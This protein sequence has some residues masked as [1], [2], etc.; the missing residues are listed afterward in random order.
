MK[1]YLRPSQREN[2]TPRYLVCL[3]GGHHLGET[4][5]RPGQVMAR[6]V[7]VGYSSGYPNLRAAKIRA[8][9]IYERSNRRVC[10]A[11][12][13]KATFSPLQTKRNQCVGTMPVTEGRGAL[14]S[15]HPL[16]HIPPCLPTKGPTLCT[17][18]VNPDG[19]LKKFATEWCAMTTSSGGQI[20]TTTTELLWGEHS[21]R[22]NQTQT[23]WV[24]TGGRLGL[25]TNVR[26]DW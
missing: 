25:G 21:T 18:R 8:L 9:G 3:G 5:L 24:N 23:W 20:S 10:P 26:S 7:R 22:R 15:G 14:E 16:L 1:N 12:T 13:K 11:H 19:V 17:R 2:T 6:N 4:S